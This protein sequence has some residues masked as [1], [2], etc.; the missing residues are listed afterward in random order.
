MVEKPKQDEQT[1]FPGFKNQPAENQNAPA[2]QHNKRA[3][4]FEPP[5]LS[6][7]IRLRVPDFNDYDEDD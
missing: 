7:A 4:G 2:K 5:N 1:A 6:K 3:K